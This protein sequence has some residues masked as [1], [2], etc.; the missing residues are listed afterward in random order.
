[1]SSWIFTANSAGIIRPDDPK[2]SFRSPIAVALP[3]CLCLGFCRTQP[4]GCSPRQMILAPPFKSVWPVEK[5]SVVCDQRQ[6]VSPPGQVAHAQDGIDRR[7]N[8]RASA[9]VARAEANLTAVNLVTSGPPAPG[10]DKLLASGA[11]RSNSGPIASPTTP[12]WCCRCH[13]H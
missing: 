7:T 2:S 6:I 10:R 11:T 4:H 8:L 12:S 5:T 13:L 1:M 9:T 3:H